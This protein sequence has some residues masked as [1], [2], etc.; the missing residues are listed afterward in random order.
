MEAK[1][2]VLV[3]D[4]HPT[5]IDG[6]KSIFSTSALSSRLK[7]FTAFDCES[8]YKQIVSHVRKFDIVLLDIGLPPYP[9]ERIL[10][11]E[12]LTA[13]IKSNHLNCKTLIITSHAETF[14]LYNLIK[15]NEPEGILVKSDFKA[16]ELVQAFEAVLRGESYF[17]ETVLQSMRSLHGKEVFLDSCN[18]KMIGLLARGIKTKNLPAH[19]NLSLSAIDKRKSQI[20]EIF[21]ISKGSDEDIIRE[22][23]K[24]GFI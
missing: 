7:F 14:M 22:A 15:R 6:F 12:D 11:G 2:N 20:K 19:L 5:M 9:D 4:D 1:I 13:L 8:A 3:V 18:R 23:K 10:S 21:N 24:R 17:S 16:E